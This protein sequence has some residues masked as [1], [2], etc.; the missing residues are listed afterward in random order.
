MRKE[1]LEKDYY[2]TLGV[3]KD[4][5]QQDIKKAFRKLARTY[6]PDNNQGD[7]AAEAKFKEINEAYE[8]IGDEESRKEYD[9]A[10]DVGYFVGDQTGGGARRVRVEDLFG[11]Q[12]F[13]AGG[14]Q[15]LYGGF[16]DLFGG[17]RAQPQKGP[18]ARGAITLSF[19]EAL[20]GAT[21]ELT[22]GGKKVKVKIPKGIAPGATV[23]VKGKGGAGSNGGPPGDVL[24]DVS[25]G[26]HP[27]FGRSGKKDLTIEVPISYTEAVLGATISIPTL[28]G[29]TRIKV[30]PGTRSGARTKLTGKGVETARG[31]GNLLV[32]F[33]IESNPDP[34]DAEREALAALRAAEANWNPRARLGVT[35]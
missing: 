10:R 6:H 4:A 2:A 27:I 15:D 34:D 25:V 16:Q 13:G 5:S 20:Q 17:R 3:A 31:T 21:R 26:S 28:S 35:P 23:R 18:D 8:T 30:L 12:G 14:S 33:V 9:H 32:T 19:H 7:D 22:L 11:G 1:W 29:E 24:V